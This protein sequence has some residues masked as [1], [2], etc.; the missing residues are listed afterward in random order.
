MREDEL[1]N[2]L[3]ALR[4]GGITIVAIHQHMV[5]EQ[6]RIILLNYW[7]IASAHDL[8][9]RTP[10]GARCHPRQRSATRSR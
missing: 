4:K 8:A 10:C 7:G 6:P 5:G 2:V 1:Q 9:K 3:K